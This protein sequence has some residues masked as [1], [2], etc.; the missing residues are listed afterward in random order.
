MYSYYEDVAGAET[1][2][3]EILDR[4][5]SQHDGRKNVQQQTFS[6]MAVEGNMQTQ[7]LIMMTEPSDAIRGKTI[8]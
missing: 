2:E 5:R 6:Q 4:S 1:A 8:E 7:L 3:V